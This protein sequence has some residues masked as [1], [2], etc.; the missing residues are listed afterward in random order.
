LTYFLDR[1]GE[2]ATKALVKDP[3]NGLDSVDG[4]LQ[5]I[6]ATDPQ[7]VS[8]SLLTVCLWIGS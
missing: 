6:K 3:E 8:L 5:Q 7:T 1:F 2:D 4:V